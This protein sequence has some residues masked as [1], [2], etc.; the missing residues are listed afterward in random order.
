MNSWYAFYPGDYARS[1]AHLSIAEHGAY[2]LLLDHYY[3][4]DAP[5]PPD[6]PALYRIARAFNRQ[7][8]A[9]VDSVVSQFFELGADGYHNRRA[10]REIARRADQHA[11]L[12]NGAKKA[13][14]NRWGS[15][16]QANSQATKQPTNQPITRPQPQ[17]Q[18]EK[19]DT[20]PSA[21]GVCEQAVTVWNENRGPLPGVL[22]LTDDRRRKVRARARATPDFLDVFKAATQ[23]AAATPF[24]RGE[25]ERGWRASFDWL[26][27]KDG[28]AIGLLEGKYDRPASG[29]GKAP[30]AAHTQAVGIPLKPSIIGGRDDNRPN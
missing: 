10:D 26:I 19:T 14:Q 18:K 24:T 8:R 28:N 16:K 13:M 6:N 11:R 23:K 12:S 30:P 7:E 25:N 21:P 15:H 1:T 4:T 29:N 3:S 17:P 2:R 9:A 5:L 22:K 20:V 27:E